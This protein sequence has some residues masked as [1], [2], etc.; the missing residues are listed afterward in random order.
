VY[1]TVPILV[2]AAEA[3]G[4]GALC[5]RFPS[6]VLDRCCCCVGLSSRHQELE[7]LA[8]AAFSAPGMHS[9]VALGLLDDSG[10]NGKNKWC[11]SAALVRAGADNEGRGV[12]RGTLDVLHLVHHL[13]ANSSAEAFVETPVV[14][15]EATIERSVD[16][17]EPFI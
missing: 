6:F 1:A 13:N 5:C 8:A 3:A 4:N 12:H 9:S 10:G 2:A 16:I 15:S 11:L 14:E 7:S 17:E